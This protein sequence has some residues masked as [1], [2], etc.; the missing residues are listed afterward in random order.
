MIRIDWVHICEMAFRDDCD[1]LCMIGVM[2]RFPAPQ[3]PIVMRQLMIVARIAGAQPEESFGIGVSM[4]TPCGV[5]LTPQRA[6]GFDIAMTP[7]YIFIT[8]RDIPLAEEGVHRFTVTIGKGDPVSIDVPV[9]LVVK[10]AQ[11]VNASHHAAA[12]FEQSSWV[13]RR[14]V[15]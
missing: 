6:D 15:N 13:S 5:S 3:L 4:V 12:V 1:R 2:T 7:E 9:R 11:D 14:E 8:L 10:Q